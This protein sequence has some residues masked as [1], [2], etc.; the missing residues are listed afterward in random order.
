MNGRDEMEK[1]WELLI[2]SLSFMVFLLSSL[3]CS[4]ATPATGLYAKRAFPIIILWLMGKACWPDALSEASASG[5]FSAEK[6]F[7]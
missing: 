2:L 7:D 1:L 5:F 3:C 6:R 4:K